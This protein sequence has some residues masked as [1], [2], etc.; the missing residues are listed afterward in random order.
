[1]QRVI[2]RI[3]ELKIYILP[4]L[5]F[6]SLSYPLYLVACDRTVCILGDEDELFEYLTA[7]FF[8]AA[9][10]FFFR[11]FLAGKNAW[12]LLLAMVF[13]VG[14]GEEISW[15]QRI[16]GFETPE[17]IANVNVQNEFSL[18]NIEV[19]NAHDFEQNMKSGPAKLLTIN[20][21][22]KLFWLAYCVLLPLACVSVR[23]IAS[24]VDKIRL[25]IPAGPIGVLFLVNWVVFK[26]TSVF[27]LPFG[28]SEQYYDT[29]GEMRECGSAFIFMVVAAYFL[30][31]NCPRQATAGNR[32]TPVLPCRSDE[33]MEGS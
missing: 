24:L 7:L 31:I 14:F 2:H 4:V 16:L 5:L 29:I 20:Y 10:W 30:D 15:G 19:F 8:L 13:L 22:Y 21:L 11:S 1:M 23:P 3:I 28:K 17:V 32:S 9:S 6:M 27:L 26:A 12:F 18:H 33:V 25:P